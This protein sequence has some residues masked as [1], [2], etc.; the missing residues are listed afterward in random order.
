MSSRVAVA[1]RQHV[2]PQQ[3][4]TIQ[5][6][7]DAAVGLVAETGYGGLTIRGVAQQA[8]V[9]P[10]TGYTF[11]SRKAPL[12]A[13]IFWRRLQVLPRPAVDGRKSAADR[14]GSATRDL[15]MLVADEP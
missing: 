6:L 15:A 4:D 2:R 7:L 1:P 3:V 14:V 10:A 9:A 11:F 8:R 12:L 13:E 5:N